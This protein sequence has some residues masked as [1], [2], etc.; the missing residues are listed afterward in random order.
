MKDF[1]KSLIALAIACIAILPS[2][3]QSVCVAQNDTDGTSFNISKFGQSFIMTSCT[4]DY[5]H[6]LVYQKVYAT[7]NVTATVKIYDGESEASGDLRYTQTNVPISDPGG[8]DTIFFSDGTCHTGNS[9]CLQFTEGNQY[10]VIIKTSSNINFKDEHASS[11][12]SGKI[13]DTNSFKNS[14]DMKFEVMV[15]NSNIIASVPVTLT[16]FFGKATNQSVLLSWTTASEHNNHGFEIERSRNGLTWE[17]I[18]F[19]IGNGSI[20]EMT[21]YEFEDSNPLRGINYYRLKQLDYDGNFEYSKIIHLSIAA[22]QHHSINLSPNP[23]SD[24]LDIQ[25]DDF[26]GQYF[27][28]YNVYGQLVK[29][30]KFK[31]NQLSIPVYDLP[32]GQY[33][34]E[35][36]SDFGQKRIALFSRN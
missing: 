1:Y 15:T 10:S 4:D 26:D 8:L 11:Y 34:L 17:K 13:Y 7:S 19:E 18:G 27:S 3:A 28:I 14:Y 32:S 20:K 16:Q 21:N 25:I 31:S 6:A 9:F 33:Y 22:S 30:G 29:T 24:I 23:V 5:F 35:I 12:T 36:R 2:S